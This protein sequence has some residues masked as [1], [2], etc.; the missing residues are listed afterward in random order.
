MHAGHAFD[1]SDLFDDFGAILMPSSLPFL[2][3]E[4]VVMRFMTSSGTSIP[5]T[6][7]FMCFC[8]ACRLERRHAS[9]DERLFVEAHVGN[10]FHPFLKFRDIVN[11]LCLYEIC[12]GSTF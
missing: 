11:N 5:G 8:S 12:A 4:A 2:A 10:H 3:A 7:Y 1:F 9:Q 6:L